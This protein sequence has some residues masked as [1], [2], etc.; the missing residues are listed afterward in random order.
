MRPA[1][2]MPAVM[3]FHSVKPLDDRLEASGANLPCKTK[4]L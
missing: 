2:A 4:F 3:E 1:S